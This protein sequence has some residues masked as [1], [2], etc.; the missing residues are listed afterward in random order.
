VVRYSVFI[1]SALSALFINQSLAATSTGSLPVTTSVAASCS[2]GAV[3]SVVFGVYSYADVAPKDAEGSISV[4]C[5]EGLAYNVGLNEGTGKEGSATN[6]RVMTGP[7]D[8]RLQ[9]GLF[10][11]SRHS[12]IWGNT[13][14]KDTVAGVGNGD[15]EDKPI[16]VYGR[17]PAGQNVPVGSYA[18][19]VTIT[20]NF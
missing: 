4:R 14:G 19:T 11:D 18:D 1:L 12:V 16:V 8:G 5:P 3:R 20:V 17:I 9:Y 2:L 6:P 15:E 10:Q 13:P 7:G